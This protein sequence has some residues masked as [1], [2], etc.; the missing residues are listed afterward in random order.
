M[1]EPKVLIY[2]IETTHNIVAQFDP[3]D[4]YTPHTNILQERYVVCAAWKW[5]GEK[6]VHTVATY[7]PNDREV[8]KALHKVLSE[9]DVIVAHNG[10]AFDKKMIETRALFHGLPT[11]PPI[12]S[13]DTYKVAKARFRFN[14]NKL[15]YLGKVLGFGGKINTPPGLWLEVL[16]G[17]K[18]AVNTMVEYNKRDVTL[19]EDVFKK[20]IPYIPNYINREL[21]G[22]AGCPR[23]GS[24]KI[25]SR[26]IHKAISRTYRRW[27]C[28]SCTGW[29]KSNKA[30]PG[31]AK[32]RIL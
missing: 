27:Q 31:T 20:L 4:E 25:Q 5:L 29:F 14:S 21:F 1:N 26:G 10:D 13:I 7:T 8:I 30:E 3:R 24:R 15:D 16:K 2:D 28:Q 22:G 23:C 17:S 32:F 18:K 6:K 9:A 19:L 11:L 12:T